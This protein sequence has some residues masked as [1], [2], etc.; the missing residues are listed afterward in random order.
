MAENLVS[1]AVRYARKQISVAVTCDDSRILLTV[2]DDSEGYPQDMLTRGTEPFLRGD[3]PSGDSE[4][5]G[6]GL[7]ICRLLCEKHGGSLA[8]Q[9]TENG[10][11]AT[12]SFYISKS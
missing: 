8:L 11:L 5:F 1:N 7:Y 3:H 2:Q 9:N 12:A 4:H 6:M 10:A